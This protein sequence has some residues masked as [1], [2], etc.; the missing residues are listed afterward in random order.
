MVVKL[1]N[2]TAV[3]PLFENWQETIIWS[4]LQKVMGDVYGNHMRRPTAAMA[5][6]G[7]FC[8]FAG[9]PDWELASYQPQGMG[10]EFRILVPQTQQWARLIA[11]IYQGKE[12]KRYAMKK[13]PEVFSRIKLRRAVSSLPSGYSLKRIDEE[14]F[15]QCKACAW[16]KDLV[17]QYATYEM[18]KALG[19]GI[20]AMNG[21]EIVS[22]AS[23]YSTYLGGIEIEIDTKEEYRRKGIAYACGGKLILECLEKGIYPSWDA[24]N[25][26][27]V[28]LAQKL[29]YHFAY[30]YTA[31]EVEPGVL[32]C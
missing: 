10:N 13:E 15:Y 12:I 1:E 2:T 4:C 25:K 31:F 22:G 20:V 29:G 18:Y 9:T 5:C 14:L 19:I 11:D 27:S 21:T 6:L 28:A 7:D 30:E 8:F 16:S 23:S 3:G 26:A 24:H 32:Q 17:S